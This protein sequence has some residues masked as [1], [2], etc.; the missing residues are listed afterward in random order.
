MQPGTFF[1]VGHCT[2]CGA[3]NQFSHIVFAGAKTLIVT[4]AA[5]GV[6]QSFNV[7]DLM[8]IKVCFA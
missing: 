8:I 7:G 6:N 1:S 3:F 4:N 5:G 2:Q